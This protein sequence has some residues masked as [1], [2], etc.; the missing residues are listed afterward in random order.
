M[1]VSAF[2]FR[3]VHYAS[4]IFRSKFSRYN[5]GDNILS[6]Y[7]KS[8]KTLFI[9]S[10]IDNMIF[11]FGDHVV[12]REHA[13]WFGHA[14]QRFLLLVCLCFRTCFYSIRFQNL[15]YCRLRDILCCL[16]LFKYYFYCKKSVDT[17]RMCGKIHW[18]MKQYF[19]DSTAR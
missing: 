15:H 13:T 7:W 9:N 3:Q 14:H 12:H 18:K 19:H 10:R 5:S 17:C 6:Q 1:T 2:Y 16:L 4:N 8:S 11:R